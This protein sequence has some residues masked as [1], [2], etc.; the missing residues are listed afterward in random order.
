MPFWRTYYHLVWTTKNRE[1]LIQRAVEKRLYAYM[2]RKAAELDVR[3]Y[4]VNGW[5]DHVHLIV[6]IP[7]K[8]SV[9]NV[10]KHLKGA[11]SH[12]LNATCGFEHSFAWQRGYGALTLGERQRA[13]AEEY[14]RN[15]K[16]H[17]EQNTANTWLEYAVEPDQG[18]PDSGL[19]LEP[20]PPAI[21]EQH[22]AYEARG[23]PP[24]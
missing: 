21:R 18:P 17:H 3:V 16:A 4:A 15:Q 6:S 5:H 23:E 13:A 24:F 11:S 8:E 7:P 14:V 1:P 22:E 10:V 20:V 19:P 9:A 12:D 2:V